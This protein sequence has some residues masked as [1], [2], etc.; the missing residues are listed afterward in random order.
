MKTSDM[1]KPERYRVKRDDSGVSFQILNCRTDFYREEPVSC[2][3]RG[4]YMNSRAGYDAA[5]VCSLTSTS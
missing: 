1:Q 5:G 2:V 3:F 4:I